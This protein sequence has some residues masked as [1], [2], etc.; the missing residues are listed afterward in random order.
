MADGAVDLLCFGNPLLD[1]LLKV[2]DDQLLTKYDLLPKNQIE[3]SE[4]QRPLFDEVFASESVTF[5]P[6]GSA[7]NT[8]RIY[9]WALAERGRVAFVGAVG[10]DKFGRRLTQLVRDDGVDIRYVVHEEMATGRSVNLVRGTDRSLVADLGAANFC[11]PDRVFVPDNLA[12]LTSATYVYVEGFFVTHDPETAMQVA[13]FCSDAG[14]QLVFSLSGTYVCQEHTDAICQMLP[15]VTFL[16][17]HVT[18]YAALARAVGRKEGE[19]DVSPLGYCRVVEAAAGRRRALEAMTRTSGEPAPSAESLS[20]GDPPVLRMVVTQSAKPVVLLDSV[21]AVSVAVPPIS[22]ALIADTTGA[23]DAVVGGFL[24]GRLLDRP[25]EEC[26][27][28]GVLA[29]REVIQLMGCAVPDRPHRWSTPT[30]AP[31]PTRPGR[32]RPPARE[33]AWSPRRPAASVGC[34]GRLWRR[35]EPSAASVNIRQIP[36]RVWNACSALLLVFCVVVYR[37]GDCFQHK[38]K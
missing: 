14:K 17:G 38:N 29:A 33:A 2:A 18:E 37:V 9:R 4:Q 16:F 22:S 27:R 31:H 5:C 24:A 13:R 11:R 35:A 15:H 1:M 3:A 8:A 10:G 36:Q 6:G 7:Q 20:S 34:S 25:L 12:L 28:F 32:R 26:L 30:P 23:G 19:F 21:R